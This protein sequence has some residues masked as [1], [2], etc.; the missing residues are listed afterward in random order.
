M[1]NIQKFKELY[2]SVFDKENNIT[3][4]GRETCKKLILCCETIDKGTNFGDATSGFM[5]PENII[6][7]KNRLEGSK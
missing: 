3:A 4:C 6:A 7:L 5:N 1:Q 2:N